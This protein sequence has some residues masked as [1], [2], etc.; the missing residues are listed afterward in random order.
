MENLKRALRLAG[1]EY[2]ESLRLP[3]AEFKK[4]FNEG[5]IDYQLPKRYMPIFYRLYIDKWKQIIVQALLLL[6]WAGIILG[7]YL[8][9]Q[10]EWLF[11]VLSILGGWTVKQWVGVIALKSIKKGL[12]TDPKYYTDLSEHEIIGIYEK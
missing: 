4:M 10:K 12:L 5:K 7:I 2:P 11:A 1:N 8:L 6:F 9:F 3:H